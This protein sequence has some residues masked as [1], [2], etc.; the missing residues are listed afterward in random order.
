MFVKADFIHGHGA[1]ALA[2]G[3]ECFTNGDHHTNEV[4]L[5]ELND[6]SNL[7]WVE[8]NHWAGVVTEGFC[9]EH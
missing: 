5:R 6:L 1:T 7:V 8:S 9:G 4:V 2:C 3:L